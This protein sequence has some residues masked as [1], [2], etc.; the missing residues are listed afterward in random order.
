MFAVQPSTFEV[1]SCS[2][3][4]ASVTVVHVII[5]RPGTKPATDGFFTELTALL[6]IVATFRN[7][8]IITGD[9][10]IHVNDVTDWRSRR[11]ADILESFGLLQSVS[12]PTHWQGNTLDLVITRS[13]GR[14]TTCSVDPPKVISDHALIVC[15]FQAY[16]SPSARSNVPFDHGRSLTA[17]RFVS[18]WKRRLSARTSRNCDI[19]PSMNC[20]MLMRIHSGGLPTTTHRPLPDHCELAV[21]ASGSMRTVGIH[22]VLHVFSNVDIE[23]QNQTSTAQHG[24]PR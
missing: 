15:Q 13:D 20:S 14:P 23:N 12:E 1:V 24:S 9:F 17:M 16:N 19:R 11:L 22:V 3:R 18:R 7:E 2:L 21:S 4:S 6:E 8:R 10:N 5:Y